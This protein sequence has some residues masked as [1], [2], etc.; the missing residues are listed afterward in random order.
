MKCASRAFLA[1]LLVTV[2]VPFAWAGPVKFKISTIG[3][4][5]SSQMDAFHNTEKEITE[6]T[7]GAVKFKIY[8]G[9]AMGTGDTLFRKI[10]SLGLSLPDKDGR[11]ATA[12]KEE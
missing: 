5:G 12:K 9:G 4:E 3:M 8:T 11:S 10:K 2:L 6:K 7:G 1:A